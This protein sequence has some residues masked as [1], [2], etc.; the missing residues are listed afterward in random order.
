MKKY[1]MIT[2]FIITLLASS[3]YGSILPLADSNQFVSAATSDIKTGKPNLTATRRT[4]TTVTLSYSKVTGATGYK[5]YRA[6][7]K[8]GTYGYV[9]A[10]KSLSYID[11]GLQYDS[12]YFYKVRAYKVVDDKKVHSKYSDVLSIYTTFSKINLNVKGNDSNSIMLSWNKIKEASSYKIYRS[13]TINGTYSYIGITNSTSYLDENLKSNETYYYRVRAYKKVNGVKYNGVYSDR[14]KATTLNITPTP[15]P[16]PTPSP[17]TKESKYA[18][19]VL[20]LVNVERKNVGLDT[21]KM[22]DIL[23]P[24]ANKRAEEIKVLFSHMRPDGREWSTIIDDYNISVRI[25]GENLAYG[26][27]TPE[28]VVTGWMNSPGHKANILNESYNNIGIGVYIYNGTVY[29]TQLF[30]N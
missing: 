6:T 8:D 18:N 29:C 15:T 25:A 21:L 2:L 3:L 16:T 10:T 23:M 24:A 13:D 4:A 20:S 17:E 7:K 12:S 11:K 22:S 9:G 14:L 28:E 5:I 1:I 26:Y 19:E 30:S 27:N